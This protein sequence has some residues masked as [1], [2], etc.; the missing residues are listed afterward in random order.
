MAQLPVHAAA[1]AKASSTFLNPSPHFTGDPAL[2][3]E[4]GPPLHRLPEPTGLS[5][6]KM[7]RQDAEEPERAGLS[8]RDGAGEKLW[9]ASQIRLL[10]LVPPP[11]PRQGRASSLIYL[12]SFVVAL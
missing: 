9:V 3:A 6:P 7:V 4:E 1:K 5:S 2:R 12:L 11:P 10:Y 8:G